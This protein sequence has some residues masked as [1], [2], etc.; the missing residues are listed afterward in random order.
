MFKIFQ[1]KWTLLATWRVKKKAAIRLTAS[2]PTV[3]TDTMNS[4]W[5]S[6][7]MVAIAKGENTRNCI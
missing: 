1:N 5:Q 7:C 6:Y 4:L 2:Y 3:Q